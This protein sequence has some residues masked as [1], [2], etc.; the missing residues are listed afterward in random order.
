MQSVD[1]T[2]Q[3]INYYCLRCEGVV[4]VTTKQITD[5]ERRMSDGAYCVN[6]DL[7]QSKQIERGAITKI[8]RT[9]RGAETQHRLK[10]EHCKVVIGY[11]EV[12]LDDFGGNGLFYLFPGIVSANP[13]MTLESVTATEL[14]VPTSIAEGKYEDKDVILLT[15]KI[16]YGSHTK[17][18]ICDITDSSVTLQLRSRFKNNEI[19]SNSII[20]KFFQRL[21]SNE[22]GDNQLLPK[23][24]ESESNRT[25]AISKVSC[26]YIYQTLL[27][28]MIG[29]EYI[30]PGWD[31]SKPQ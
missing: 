1:D 22:K 6:D 19:E 4:L 27:K 29:S 3:S 14:H 8:L 26:G 17:I 31:G 18:Q 7:I 9:G 15:L 5:S 11:K 24:I 13:T 16:C 20:V 25:L 12:D 23:N 10:C 2:S 30:Y 21:L 28:V